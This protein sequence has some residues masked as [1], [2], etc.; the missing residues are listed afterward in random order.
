MKKPKMTAKLTMPAFPASKAL[1]AG[2]A[3][4]SAFAHHGPNPQAHGH[5]RM[6]R[7]HGGKGPHN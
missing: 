5:D 4:L 3:M 1:K 2:K 6:E 7:P